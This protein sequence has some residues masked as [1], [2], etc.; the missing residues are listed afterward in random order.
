MRK[1]LFTK[2]TVVAMAMVMA[3]SVMTGCGKKAQ[4]AISAESSVEVSAE[5]TV[6]SSEETVESTE[7]TSEETTVEAQKK[8][9]L[10]LQNRLQ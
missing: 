9:L 8:Q 3:S 7:E 6:E 5:D 4:N 10:K 2:M 1:T